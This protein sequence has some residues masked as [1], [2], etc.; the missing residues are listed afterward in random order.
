MIELS[1]FELIRLLIDMGLLILTWLV[2]LVIYPSFLYYTSTDLKKWHSI[3]TRRITIVVL[4]LMLSQLLVAIIGLYFIINWQSI[5]YF[6]VILAT[7]GLTF[8]RAIPLHLEIEKSP[9]QNIIQQLLQV[10]TWRTVLW[11]LVFIFSMFKTF[12]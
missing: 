11:T 1:Y 5:L 12:F 3:Y 9:N 2:Q 6:F 7:W 8:L 4:P 10:H